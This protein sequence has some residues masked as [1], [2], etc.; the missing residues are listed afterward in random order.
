MSQHFRIPLWN[1]AGNYW[2]SYKTSID[3]SFERRNGQNTDK[4][5]TSKHKCMPASG[6]AG[7]AWRAKGN[8]GHHRRH[9]CCPLYPKFKYE[10]MGGHFLIFFLDLLS[11]LYANFFIVTHADNMYIDRKQVEFH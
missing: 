9:L 6:G 2:T 3:S 7:C 10:E 4:E 5:C 1:F 8:Q 11:Y